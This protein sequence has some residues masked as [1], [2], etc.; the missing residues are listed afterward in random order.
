MSHDRVDVS[1]FRGSSKLLLRLLYSFTFAYLCI[2]PDS[3]LQFQ[4]CRSFTSACFSVFFLL[5]DL[6]TLVPEIRPLRVHVSCL[7]V[8]KQA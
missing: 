1:P 6:W 5:R 7:L 2:F 4:F 8:Y 3:R